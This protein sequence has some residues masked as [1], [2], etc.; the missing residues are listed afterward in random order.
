MEEVGG[1]MAWIFERILHKPNLAHRIVPVPKCLPLLA[2]VSRKMSS[3]CILIAHTTT[4]TGRG[5][6]YRQPQH[7][8]CTSKLALIQGGCWGDRGAGGNAESGGAGCRVR[9]GA[10]RRARSEQIGRHHMDLEKISD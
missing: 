8:S 4:R 10:G 9:Y 1:G 2:L 3:P 6:S 7:C 5:Y